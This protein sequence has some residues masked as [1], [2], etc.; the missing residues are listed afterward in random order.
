LLMYDLLHLLIVSLA[1]VSIPA[2]TIFVSESYKWPCGIDILSP[3]TEIDSIPCA[4]FSLDG[5]KAAT[6]RR[7]Q[8]KQ[9]HWR[10]VAQ[11]KSVVCQ[12]IILVITVCLVG[13]TSFN[14]HKEALRA[15]GYR[16]SYKPG[17]E[18]ILRVQSVST[19]CTVAHLGEAGRLGSQFMT[20]GSLTF[21]F[22]T[23]L[24]APVLYVAD[25]LNDRPSDIPRTVEPDRKLR[26]LS[27]KEGVTA[28]I[29]SLSLRG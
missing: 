10:D 8:T 14:D 1:Q 28:V 6:T 13:Q 17:T 12:H 24:D 16:G 20:A 22:D 7:Q 21:Y 23:K 15:L 19:K 9:R 26:R 2:L 5:Q 25:E 11:G 4:W 29:H 3:T 18:L 27:F